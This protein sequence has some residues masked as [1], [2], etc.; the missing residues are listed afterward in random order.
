MNEHA[1]KIRRFAIASF[2]IGVVVATVLAYFS[3]TLPRYQILDSRLGA[4][5]W[6]PT[7]LVA[8][9]SWE[10]DRDGQNPLQLGYPDFFDFQHQALLRLLDIQHRQFGWRSLR[11]ATNGAYI[12]H[13]GTYLIE[14]TD[15]QF[16]VIGTGTLKPVSVDRSPIDGAIP[17]WQMERF[18]FTS[19]GRLLSRESDPAAS[20]FK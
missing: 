2:I 6:Q 20:P 17:Y 13:S 10:Y 7:N 15:S 16:I 1:S 18:T 14:H 19:A 12:D 4:S 11:R 9:L 8:I 3:L 5:A